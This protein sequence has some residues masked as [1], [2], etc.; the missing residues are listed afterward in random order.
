D[1]YPLF[2]VGEA[3][4]LTAPFGEVLAKA[5]AAPQPGRL[6]MNAMATL[7]SG[8]VADGELIDIYFHVRGVDGLPPGLYRLGA[9]GSARLRRRARPRP[10]RHGRFLR[11]RARRA[12]RPRRDRRRR[13]DPRRDRPGRLT[14]PEHKPCR[15]AAAPPSTMPSDGRGPSTSPS[16]PGGRARRRF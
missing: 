13:A 10:R 3:S 4:P 12:P 8:A 11:S 2:T 15:K 16:A 7:L 1:Q 9:R 5:P 14:R 6:S